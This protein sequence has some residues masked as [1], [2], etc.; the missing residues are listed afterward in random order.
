MRK[1]RRGTAWRSI[2]ALFDA[3][4][5]GDLTDG[6]LLRRFGD[7]D[8][9]PE[10]AE[11]A[12]AALVERHGPM[13]LRA[14][15]AVAGDEH[16]AQDA[17]QATFLVLVRRAGTL[18]VRDSIGPWLLAVARR[19]AS[20]ARDDSA[21]RRTRERRAARDAFAESPASDASADDLGAAV[22]EE[23]DRLPAGFRAAVVLCALEG[24]TCEQAARRLGWPSGTVRSR[25]ARGK[26]RL[27]DRLARRG[28]AP[29]VAAGLAG[30]TPTA[31]SVP[32]A[33][34]RQTVRGATLAAADPRAAALARG[35]LRMTAMT[36]LRWAAS[37]ALA[38]VA[39]VALRSTATAPAGA[40]DPPKTTRV[41]QAVKA[42]PAPRLQLTG[43]TA[44]DEDTVSRVRT[45]VDA[46]VEKVLIKVGQHVKK[47]EPVAELY[48]TDLAAAKN[49][50]QTRWVQ[51]QHDLKLYDLRR[52]LFRTAVLSEQV[53]VDTQNDEQKSRLAY[54]LA[55]DKL[56]LFYEIPKDE[57]DPLIDRLRDKALDPR[58]FGDNHDKARLT[59][60]SPAEGVVIGR[61]VVPETSSNP[62]TP[63]R[64]SPGSTG[65]GSSPN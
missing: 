63:W 16:D 52:K 65:C 20:R 59:L 13:V 44:Y 1:P 6:Q 18:W 64:R 46:R 24:L 41:A 51:W 40:A 22:H 55:R 19:V 27:R 2:E 28:Y 53:W 12:F 25:L 17:F 36:P 61:D 5:A 56:T 34:T 48:S 31:G 42:D 47:G 11:R 9:G 15:R 29:S 43:R 26:A 21:R 54:D 58:K 32:A 62:R 8:L 4:V 57:I 14:C 45:L 37:T 23:V 10:S 7:R 49:D 39:I 30:A 35:V 33:L 3:G 38:F 50:F 60:R